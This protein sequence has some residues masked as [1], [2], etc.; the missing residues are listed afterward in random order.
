MG[1]M[2]E[3]NFHLRSGVVPIC[4]FGKRPENVIGFGPNYLSEKYRKP[5]FNRKS[6]IDSHPRFLG[7]YVKSNKG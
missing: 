4:I 3:P 2:V 5:T 6:P 1:S 7:E